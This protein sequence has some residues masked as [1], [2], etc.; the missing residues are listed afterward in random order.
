V[1]DAPAREFL[2]KFLGTNEYCQDPHEARHG[3]V[4]LQQSR[5]SCNAHILLAAQVIF[6]YRLLDIYADALGIPCYED[7]AVVPRMKK[8]SVSVGRL[9][10]VCLLCIVWCVLTAIKIFDHL[11]DWRQPVV[12]FL[13][14]YRSRD[15]VVTT[16][17]PAIDVN[18][19]ELSRDRNQFLA[20]IHCLKKYGAFQQN[21]NY[22]KVMGNIMALSFCIWWMSIVC[23]CSVSFDSG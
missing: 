14:M 7:L 11:S 10:K 17:V 9:D 5:N 21:K 22:N 15:H 13:K 20:G 4:Q 8:P 12:Q 3:L 19:P 23:D 6:R 16:P 2:Q 18:G 1:Y